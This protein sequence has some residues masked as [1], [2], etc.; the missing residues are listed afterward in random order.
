MEQINTSIIKDYFSHKKID[1]KLII[2]KN[3]FYIKLLGY[4]EDMDFFQYLKFTKQVTKFEW[5]FIVL[6]I[7]SISKC[8]D[9]FVNKFIN[10]YY[11][12]FPLKQR[13]RIIKSFNYELLGANIPQVIKLFNKLS[14]Y[15]KEKFISIWLKKN[16]SPT[17]LIVCRLVTPDQMIKYMN[18]KYCLCCAI[19][20]YNSKYI[21]INT[22]L[23]IANKAFK[24]NEYYNLNTKTWLQLASI[25]LDINYQLNL[26][27]FNLTNCFSLY[28]FKKLV[29]LLPSNTL[30]IIISNEKLCVQFIESLVE[31]YDLDRTKEIIKFMGKKI[32][33]TF[34]Q[35][36]I[37][38]HSLIKGLNKYTVDD[39]FVYLIK[40]FKL[41]PKD[42]GI[43]LQNI[44]FD[45]HDF[46]HKLDK[47]Y[48]V[49]LKEYIIDSNKYLNR[50]FKFDL[51]KKFIRYK[52][53]NDNEI[54]YFILDNAH[55]L[56]YYQVKKY[57]KNFKQEYIQSLLNNTNTANS[58]WILHLKFNITNQELVENVFAMIK[59][60]EQDWIIYDIL[61]SLLEKINKE[62]IQNIFLEKLK[63]FS[64][65]RYRLSWLF[66]DILRLC[67]ITNPINL[68]TSE[69]EDILTKFVHIYKRSY[70]SIQEIKKLYLIA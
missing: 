63:E 52:L 29:K 14:F 13:L 49:Y 7:L 62:N 35:K 27:T 69:K 20:L 18:E 60:N 58:L 33:P 5:Y 46:V 50:T 64:V 12:T 41:E 23:E 24:S 4:F 34:E 40:I 22:L 19:N 9:Q 26:L 30:S 36:E 28:P 10:E 44:E 21:D 57:I 65:K 37:L 53:L 3:T 47:P 61:K 6:I 66:S 38:I 2:Y 70:F 42:V 54:K 16:Y 17:Q 43:I 32:N 45:I 48:I 1:T 8:S 59:P 39:I 31:Y 51:F 25:C 56:K 67:L 11:N 68:L 55:Y 15:E